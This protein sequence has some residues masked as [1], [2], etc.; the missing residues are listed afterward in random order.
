V[1]EKNDDEKTRELWVCVVC[2][3]AY[4]CRIPLMDPPLLLWCDD[5]CR[6]QMTDNCTKLRGYSGDP[7]EPYKKKVGPGQKL[8]FVVNKG[9]CLDHFEE[10]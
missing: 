1:S 2:G 9:K 5:A 7:E 10:T 8:P 3:I 6:F 4:C